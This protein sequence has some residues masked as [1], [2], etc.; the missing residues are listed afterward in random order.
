MGSLHK[1]SDTGV[2]LPY[3]REWL[4]VSLISQFHQL[5]ILY[6]WNFVPMELYLAGSMRQRNFC[7]LLED[8]KGVEVRD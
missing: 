2:N 5:F 1:Y 7:G 8:L 6:G 3:G 4:G